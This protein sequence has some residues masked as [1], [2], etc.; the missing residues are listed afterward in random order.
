ME[1][2]MAVRCK[3]LIQS[4][5]ACNIESLSKLEP[6]KLAAELSGTS[7]FT[8]QTHWDGAWWSVLFDEAG[9]L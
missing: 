7:I 3:I 2:T 9:C 4:V 8:L 5:S 6:Q 1:L